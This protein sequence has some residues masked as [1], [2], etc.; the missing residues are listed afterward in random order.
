MSDFV[1]LKPY[2]FPMPECAIH[3]LSH[4]DT[5]PACEVDYFSPLL[6]IYGLIPPSAELGWKIEVYDDFREVVSPHFHQIRT[7]LIMVLE[8]R[9]K[10]TLG[11]H[12]IIG[13]P[14]QFLSIPPQTFHAIQPQTNVRLLVI[15]TPAFNFPEDIFTQNPPSQDSPQT[16]FVLPVL[17]S[18]AILDQQTNLTT[19]ILETFHIQ[20][21]IPEKYYLNRINNQGY[22]AYLLACEPHNKWSIAIL[23]VHEAPRH[24]H[25]FGSEHFIVL[26]GEL[27]INLDGVSHILKAGQSVHIPPEI[28]HHLRSKKP[29]PVRLLCV[30]YPSFDSNDFY[31]IKE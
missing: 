11:T 15:D 16:A 9:C 13:I 6:T 8:G 23:D 26:S 4:K 18:A 17:Q 3:P 14:G 7:Q 10:I 2:P 22:V 5:C 30:N 20:D 31:Q 28:T 21:T 25:K 24:F 19:Q 1:P 27:D 29:T 12:D